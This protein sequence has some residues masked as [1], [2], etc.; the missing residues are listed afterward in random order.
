MQID[1]TDVDDIYRALW[2]LQRQ[3]GCEDLLQFRSLTTAHQYSRLVE[4]VKA[5]VSSGSEVLDWGCGNGHFSYTLRAL[6]YRT[7]GFGFDDFG[8]RNHIPPPYS[9]TR[10]DADEPVALPYVSNN[11]D[12][13]VS[14]GVLEHVRE[15]GGAE[16]ASLAEIRRVLRPGG[17]FICY[18]FP[19]RFSWIEAIRARFPNPPVHRY[20]YTKRDIASLFENAGM[21]CVRME[22]Y[23]ALPRNFWHRA[24]MVLRTSTTF[25]KLWNALDDLLAVPL[26]LI[27]QNHVFV[28][29]KTPADRAT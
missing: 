4:L 5:N 9:F 21:E 3:P 26:N 6:G 23:G 25:A 22:R 20:R 17:V 12:A 29:R 10:G 11:F 7:A 19:N 8:L 16:A 27:C 2:A 24:P 1:D 13:V 15:T 28:A 14:V 18:H